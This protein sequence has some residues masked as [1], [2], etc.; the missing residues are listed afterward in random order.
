MG[1]GIETLEDRRLLSA[2]LSHGV[3][4]VVGTPGDDVINVEVSYSTDN[5]A[6]FPP[7]YFVSINGVGQSFPEPVRQLV[8]V[9]KGGNDR[10]SLNV[11]G[12]NFDLAAGFG[13]RS[14]QANAVVFAGDGDD[15]VTGG[16]GNDILFGGRGADTLSGGAGNDV[17]VGQDGNDVLGDPAW[18]L[19]QSNPSSSPAQPISFV[20]AYND[21]QEAGNDI[22]IGGN[23]D[24]ALG[25][26]TGN[27]WLSGGAGKDTLLGGD[28]RDLLNGGGGNDVLDGGTGIDRV[29]GG[30]GADVFYSQPD[31]RPQIVD[32]R[33]DDTDGQ[34]PPPSLD[35]LPQT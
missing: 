2:V 7:A 29:R 24:D 5:P 31:P 21:A 6:A 34:T 19:T 11:S 28:G 9:A 10:V 23:G 26:G 17:L 20:E 14:V 32:M 1:F 18:S 12:I 30:L 16:D 22:L 27:D 15:L 13:I 4:R 35:Q 3:L 8:V 25:G 33:R